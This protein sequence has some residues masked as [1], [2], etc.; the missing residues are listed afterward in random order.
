[1]TEH[2]LDTFSAE[3]NFI[4]MDW[5]P[6]IIHQKDFLKLTKIPYIPYF[7]FGENLPVL[8]QGTSDPTGLGYAYETYRRAFGRQAGKYR[9]IR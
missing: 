9:R 7:S 8:E 3:L 4:Y 1:L 2:W 6:K 5:L